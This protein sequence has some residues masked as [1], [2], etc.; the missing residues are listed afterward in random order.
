MSNVLTKRFLWLGFFVF[1]GLHGVF[2]Q[3]YKF[4]QERWLNVPPIPS[5]FSVRSFGL[6]DT[7]FAYRILCVLIQNLGD[8]GGRL[9]VFPSYDYDRLVRWFRLMDRLDPESDYIPFL[10][11]YYFSAVQTPEKL[12]PLIAYL[13]EVGSRPQVEGEKWRWLLQAIFLARHRQDDL[14]KALGLSKKLADIYREGMP[15]WTR[16]MSAFIYTETGEKEAAL[17]IM[18]SILQEMGDKIHPV[19]ARYMKGYICD[20]LLEPDQRETSAFC[21]EFQ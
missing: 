4:V 2:L 18:A 12:D 5:D 1:V 16:H 13:A 17:Q 3:P 6:G 14:D 20:K 8:T 7:Q 19:E 11:A 10:A 9:N 15:L 21:Q